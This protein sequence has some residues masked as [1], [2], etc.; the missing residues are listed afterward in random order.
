MIY[1]GALTCTGMTGKPAYLVQTG[2]GEILRYHNSCT[3]SYTHHCM[4]DDTNCNLSCCQHF[5]FEVA[6]LSTIVSLLIVLPCQ[7]ALI[8]VMAPGHYNTD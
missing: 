7:S 4:A 3:L 2:S 1:S 5:V 6:G 8:D